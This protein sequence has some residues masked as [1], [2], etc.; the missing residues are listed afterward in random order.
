[1]Q[2]LVIN[3]N[4]LLS[5]HVRTKDIFVNGDHCF[6]CALANYKYC[7][8]TKN[9]AARLTID[10]FITNVSFVTKVSSSYKQCLACMERSRNL[11]SHKYEG[12]NSYI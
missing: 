1:M 12:T 2:C 11:L 5:N 9:V 8:R 3:N 4:T 7:A 10:S 6:L